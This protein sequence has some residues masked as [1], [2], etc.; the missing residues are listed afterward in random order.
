MAAKE[1]IRVE[2]RAC[3]A[4]VTLN[5]PDSLNAL[6]ID[7]MRRF[8]EVIEDVG[9]DDSIRAV[10][11]TGA[12]RGFCAGADLTVLASDD[13]AANRMTIADCL[14]EFINPALASIAAMP[15]PVVA[16]VNGPAAGAGCGIAL[17]ADI[18]VAARSARFI[19]S[20]SNIGASPDAGSSWI[21]PRLLGPSKAMALMML[22]EPVDA[23]TACRWSM[24]H[25]VYEDADLLTE[26][27]ELAGRLAQGPAASFAAIKQL[28]RTA[29]SNDLAAQLAMEADF[30]EAAFETDDL[31]E[32]I[33]AFVERRAPVFRL[34]YVD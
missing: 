10:L 21:L 34:S 5:R 24:V 15:K 8:R 27:T 12:G 28:V 2:R 26:A 3:V 33:A 30:Q 1:D 11:L 25:K 18:V 31:R 29:R 20:F 22:G 4:I 19:Q 16:A 7:M 32:G 14:R 17:M 23:E 6:T 9:S 13:V